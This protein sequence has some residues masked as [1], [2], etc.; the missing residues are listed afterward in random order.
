MQAH[1]PDMGS[2]GTAA[3]KLTE[4]QTELYFMMVLVVTLVAALLWTIRQ[5]RITADRFRDV[6]D[7]V[8][9]VYRADNAQTIAT[10]MLIQQ[11]IAEARKWVEKNTRLLR[12]VDGKMDRTLTLLDRLK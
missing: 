5:A 12:L 3:Q 7:K 1:F 8:T 4:A 11:D 10:N 9:D 2:V 6:T